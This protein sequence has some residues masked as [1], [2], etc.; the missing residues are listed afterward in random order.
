MTTRPIRAVHPTV[1]L[2]AGQLSIRVLGEQRPTWWSAFPA[3]DDWYD[4]MP[5]YMAEV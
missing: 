1:V 5:P 3:Q 4:P 2:D